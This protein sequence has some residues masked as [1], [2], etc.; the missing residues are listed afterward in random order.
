MTRGRPAKETL[1]AS[2]RISVAE[3]RAAH[4]GMSDH[5][6]AQ[7]IAALMSENRSLPGMR[8]EMGS[9]KGADV[10]RVLREIAKERAGR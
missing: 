5:A 9:S 7:G 3:W 6:I 4:P 2:L 10:K 8:G 1:N